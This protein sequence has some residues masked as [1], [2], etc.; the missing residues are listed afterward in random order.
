M[1][2][3]ARHPQGPPKDADASELF[4]L[5]TKLPKPSK[6]IDFPRKNPET[7]EAV[8]QLAL[9]PLT[10]AEF[11]GARAA[12]EAYARMMLDDKDKSKTPGDSL[13]YKDIYVNALYVELLARACRDPKFPT[14]KVPVW[15]QGAQQIRQ[16]VFP[17]EIAILFE[18]YSFWQSEAGPIISHM[19]LEEMRAWIALLA[20][21]GSSVPLA[22]L[23]SGAKNEL[24][25]FM[26]AQLLS[27]W[28]G[29]SSVG[30]PPEELVKT[31]DG[32]QPPPVP[33]ADILDT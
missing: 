14:L 5:L 9:V 12:A 22:S 25:I 10:E 11:M 3:V 32:E 29:S 2:A 28:T 1:A 23:S 15:P 20:K 19:D 30:S 21:G 13:G 27:F 7:D 33:T 26:A 24:L 4:Q 17:D 31:N 16:M 6:L 18:S 8:F